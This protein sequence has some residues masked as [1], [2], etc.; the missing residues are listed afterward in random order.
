MADQLRMPTEHECVTARL[1]AG[2]AKKAAAA[3]NADGRWAKKVTEHYIRQFDEAYKCC[4][5]EIDAAARE[6]RAPR[7]MVEV[8]AAERLETGG[9]GPLVV[10]A[11]APRTAR[12]INELAG[13]LGVGRQRISDWKAKADHDEACEPFPSGPPYEVDEVAG[14]RD[15]NIDRGDDG[16]KGEMHE[17]KV[18]RARLD[19]EE[20]TRKA[21]REQERLIARRDHEATLAARAQ[22]TVR[23]VDRV[24]REAAALFVGIESEHEALV[25]LR[26]AI[27]QRIPASIAEELARETTG[28][29]ARHAL[30]PDEQ[31]T[32]ET[33]A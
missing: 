4:T 30:A 32:R 23:V 13:M 29:A 14:W 1:R 16:E 21:A 6:Q 20:K 19:L 26:S 11:G 17:L 7:S 9:E 27:G 31:A 3:L 25:R 8:L 28:A 10:D 22:A 12:T 15:R 5:R 24:C 33:A 2:S 18:R